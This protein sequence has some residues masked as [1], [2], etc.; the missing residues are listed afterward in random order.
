MPIPERVFVPAAKDPGTGHFAVSLIKSMFR[1][2]S[3]AMLIW[4]GYEFYWV[5]HNTTDTFIGNGGVWMMA[6][7]VGLLLAEVLGIIEE[8]V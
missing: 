6:A 5:L 8:I 2:I 3:C 4:A 1:I 7:G